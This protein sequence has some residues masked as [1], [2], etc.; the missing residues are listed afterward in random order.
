MVLILKLSFLSFFNFL[1]IYDVKNEGNEFSKS[2][3]GDL[4]IYDSN[5]II[6]KNEETLSPRL[7]KIKKIDIEEEEKFCEKKSIT[8][9]DNSKNKN[10]I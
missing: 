1:D 10:Y 2:H 8:E 7:E 5:K 3:N 6:K 4:K 9:I